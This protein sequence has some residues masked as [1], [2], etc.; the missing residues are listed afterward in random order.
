MVRPGESAVVRRMGDGSFDS[1]RLDSELLHF[2]L[3]K[4][5]NQCLA[6]LKRKVRNS[7]LTVG[8]CKHPY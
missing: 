6:S 7:L 5:S 3:T 1:E 4:C 8:R 2:H